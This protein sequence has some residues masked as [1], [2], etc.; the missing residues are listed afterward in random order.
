MPRNLKIHVTDDAAAPTA[1]TV[2][3]SKQDQIRWISNGPAFTIVFKKGSPFDKDTFD[4]PADGHEQ[5][6]SVRSDV[7]PGQAFRYVVKGP[8]DDP[9]DPKVYVED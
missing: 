4:I 8:G 6:G 2:S 5:S 9:A 1:P 7:E 3:K